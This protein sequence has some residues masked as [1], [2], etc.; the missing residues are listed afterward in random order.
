MMKYTEA[1]TLV[2]RRVYNTLYDSCYASLKQ[3]C[4]MLG[5][6]HL[7]EFQ[8]IPLRMVYKPSGNQIIFRGLDNMESITSITTPKGCLC[9]AWIEEMYQV[10]DEDMFNKLD[11]S[12]RSPLPKGYFYRIIGSLNPWRDCWIRSRFFDNP[13]ENTLAL[14]TTYKCNEFLSDDI[15]KLMDDLYITN[16]R[17][18]R[19]ECDGEF[20]ISEGLVYENVEFKYFNIEEISKNPSFKAIYGCDLGWKDKTALICSYISKADREI[21]VYDELYR[22][23]ITNQDLADILKAKGLE[24]ERII[25][26]SAEPKSIEELKRAGI[27]N[28]T[29]CIKGKGSVDYG[30]Q[31]VQNYKIIVHPNCEE[32]AK[33]ISNYAYL[34]NGKTTHEWSHGCDGLRY[35]TVYYERGLPKP[36]KRLRK[37][38]FI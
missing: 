15:R 26:D 8:K 18:A 21:Y 37:S 14:T 20:G 38:W 30:I 5:V 31:L 13:D 22:N 2:V 23:K 16:P 28:A 27:H 25:F 6:S 17:R 11:L 32:F 7:W 24:D 35:S 10:E 34:E 1:N 29:P 33:E 4:D 19:V 3:A 12:I 36:K 9:W